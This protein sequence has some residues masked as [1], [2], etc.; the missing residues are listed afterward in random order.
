MVR[1]VTIVLAGAV[2]A[3]G[4]L[5]GIFDL[6]NW[7]ST[8]GSVTAITSMTSWPGNGVV[9]ARLRSDV[10]N[11]QSFTAPVWISYSALQASALWQRI[12]RGSTT[13]MAA[14]RQSGRPPG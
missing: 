2:A 14:S 1:I 9:Y 5:G 11:T 8:V 10:G 3:F 13:V 6:I 7:P 12:W 4:F